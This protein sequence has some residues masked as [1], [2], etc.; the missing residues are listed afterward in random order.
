MEV[1]S[2]SCCST[3]ASSFTILTSSWTL[4]ASNWITFNAKSCLCSFCHI[5]K[6]KCLPTMKLWIKLNSIVLHL[7]RVA[8]P[9]VSLLTAVQSLSI[10]N[11]PPNFSRLVSFESF[12]KWN[13]IK[14]RHQQLQIESNCYH[15]SRFCD[16][17][18]LRSV[19]WK[20]NFN[21][22]LHN[23][24]SVVGILPPRKRQRQSN[25]A[26]SRWKPTTKQL[27]WV[28][29]QKNAPFFCYSKL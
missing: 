28:K 27:G 25:S 2:E 24:P 12:G 4:L 16:V 29:L 3:L 1:K 21:K 19:T 5:E 6:Q 18:L 26:S 11:W 20:G 7:I 14:I 10:P 17:T 13:N 8:P 23:F 9:V 22:F 15:R